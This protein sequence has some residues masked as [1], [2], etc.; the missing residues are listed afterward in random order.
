MKRPHI[1]FTHFCFLCA[2]YSAALFFLGCDLIEQEASNVV[3]VLGS[4]NITADELKKDMEFIS[5]DMNLKE[6]QHD[7]IRNQLAEQVISYYL[8]IEYANEKGISI[9]E[10][11]LQY[12]LD[13]IKREYTEDVFKE[14]L[15]REYVDFDQWKNRFKEQLLINK[16][17][18]EVAKNIAPPSHKEIEQYYE[19]NRDKFRYPKMVKF[20][21]I[22]SKS[23]KEADNLLNRIHKGEEMGAL[24]RQYSIGP[25]ADNGGE[26]SWVAREHLDE[27]MGNVL[28]SLSPGEMS[29]VVE[30]PYGYHIFE[31]LSVRPETVKEL[32]DVIQE[33]ELKLFHEKREIFLRDWLE[34]LRTHFEVKVD[35]ELMAQL[36]LY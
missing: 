10:K 36:D 5:A 17:L 6:K 14:A 15:L 7:Q 23:K 11:E 35:Q 4:R 12:A 33:I 21:Q 28:F 20:R 27:S 22:V 26:I 8:I 24:A 13:D 25:E 30:T 32:P 18:K 31:V 16:I 2:F 19:E 3:I 29:R 34:D 1:F 9:S